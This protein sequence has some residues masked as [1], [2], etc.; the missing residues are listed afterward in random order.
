LTCKGKDKVKDEVGVKES[1]GRLAGSPVDK[2]QNT[3]YSIQN[4]GNRRKD[5]VEV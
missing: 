5:K 2:I 3:E 1:V 4:T